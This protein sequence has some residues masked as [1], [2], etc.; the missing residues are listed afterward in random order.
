M[1]DSSDK[2]ALPGSLARNPRLSQWLT[3][4][5]EGRVLLRTGKVEIGQG[6]LTALR[7]IAADELD[8]AIDRL[9]VQPASTDNGP[10]EGVT[11]GSRSIQESG[12]AIRHASACAR[13]IHISICSQRT[14]V[15]PEQIRIDDGTFVGPG[16]PLG[17]YWSQTDDMILECDAD[18]LVVPKQTGDLRLVGT[19]SARLD[20]PDKVFGA[21]R[22]IH[23]MRLDGMRFARVVRP[24]SR[25]AQLGSVDDSD[26]SG[27][28]IVD[29]NFVAVVCESESA[30]NAAATKLANRLEWTETD[31][32][33]GN[34]N[35]RDWLRSVAPE[36]HVEVSKPAEAE[37]ANVLN[38]EVFRPYVAH[39]SMAPSC[40]VAQYDGSTLEVWCHS[41]GIFNLRRDIAMALKLEPE[42]VVVR[43]RE[44][45]GCYGHNGADDVAFDAAY[46]AF[47]RPGAPVR[48][49]WSREDELSWAPFSSAM[50]VAME[51][52]LDSNGKIVSWKQTVTSH[53]HSS[54]PASG[55]TPSLL[56]ASQLKDGTPLPP[57]SDPPLARGGG[58]HRN[59]V[60]LYETG[61]LEVAVSLVAETPLRVSS[62]R[63]LG[64]M[65]N[66]FA[67]ET[68]MNELA[69]SA[70]RD[71]ADYRIEH[72]TDD[73]AIAVIQA[74]KE[75]A[76][77]A[78]S[79]DGVGLG[80]AFARYKN[81]AAYCAIIAKVEAEEEIRVRHLWIAAD[82]GEI[83]NPEGAAHQIEGGAVQACSFALK[84][85]V[86]FDRRQVLSFNWEEYPILR[87]SE[88]PTVDVKLLMPPGTP[89]LGVGECA[90]GPTIAA[91]SNAIHDAIGV[92]PTTMPFTA[93]NLAQEILAE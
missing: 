81:S 66:V 58:S 62:L 82:A 56:G 63:S 53:G 26:V 27:D 92:R 78:T 22:F 79:D 55:A 73:R 65:A 52:G 2:P 40:A 57:T 33:A 4:E 91:I 54:R 69:E 89:P 86:R 15:A 45:A 10:D 42:D 25:G 76:G 12:L 5:P 75:M 36:P 41:Q 87:F 23:D 18:P 1:A 51:A 28:V 60:P 90:T 49:M 71:P 44:G 50:L 72:L 83:I 16:G 67:V 70:G 84:E 61:G 32:L 3:I 11:S 59:A 31:T 48:V 46:I 93:A 64:G 17:S 8:V 14:G 19:A 43:H 30:A 77:D 24:P 85:E 39:A 9:E 7:Q 80:L 88:V 6:I 13:A 29:G 74:V 37:A 20:L 47:K 38:R 35:V 21:P 34:E 68:M